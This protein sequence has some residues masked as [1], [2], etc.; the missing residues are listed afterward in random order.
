MPKLRQLTNSG[1]VLNSDTVKA[2]VRALIANFQL[3]DQHLYSHPTKTVGAARHT[4]VN[5]AEMSTKPGN[6]LPV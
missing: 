2:I 1:T 3:A 6:T 4:F 5:A